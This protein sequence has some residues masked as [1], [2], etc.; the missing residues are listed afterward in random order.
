MI[1][2]GDDL[3]AELWGKSCKKGMLRS[4]TSPN[5]RWKLPKMSEIKYYAETVWALDTSVMKCCMWDILLLALIHLALEQQMFGCEFHLGRFKSQN[6]MSYSMLGHCPPLPSIVL[7][8][9]LQLVQTIQSFVFLKDCKL[10]DGLIPFFQQRPC[11]WICWLNTAWTP[12]QQWG[13]VFIM[14]GPN[15]FFFSFFFLSNDLRSMPRPITVHKMLAN[16]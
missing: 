10:I 5:V 8:I 13:F 9:Q 3:N 2:K 4:M 14:R 12:W 1:K 16:W 11:M 15:L 6:T 7:F